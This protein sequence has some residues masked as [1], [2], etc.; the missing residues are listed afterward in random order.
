VVTGRNYPTGRGVEVNRF[1]K[2]QSRDAAHCKS[3]QKGRQ[4]RNEEEANLCQGDLKTEFLPLEAGEIK[5]G[6]KKF[7][8]P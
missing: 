6:R 3:D 2:G 7:K 4:A 8:G 5:K 1:S